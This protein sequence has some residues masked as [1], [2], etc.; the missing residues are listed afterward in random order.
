MFEQIGKS[1]LRSGI[2][3]SLLKRGFLVSQSDNWLF[4]FMSQIETFHHAM[5][6]DEL[7][8]TETALAKTRTAVTVVENGQIKYYYA[9]EFEQSLKDI[10]GSAIVVIPV[11]GMMLRKEN[12]YTR[13]GYAT[14]TEWLEK[15]TKI[16]KSN[17]NIKG[18][19]YKV[20]S[21]GGIGYGNQSLSRL[22]ATVEVPTVCFF[23]NCASAALESFKSCDYIIANE[24]DSKIGSY[25]SYI[26]YIFITK[27][28]LKEYGYDVVEV[29]APQS[30]HKNIESREAENGNEE[31]MKS[32]LQKSV[33]IMIEDMKEHRPQVTSDIWEDGRIFNAV[34]AQEINL[35][36]DIMS[37]DATIEFVQSLIPEPKQQ[38]GYRDGYRQLAE[39]INFN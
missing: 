30:T 11:N 35:V 1:I 2:S 22:I 39:N 25:G 34:E 5:E 7:A 24:S 36:D 21:G 27:D 28:G 12:Y 20:N 13:Y 38:N 9:S 15:V 10:E 4:S 17:S 16:C 14:S 33:A 19:I 18:I 23:D 3:Q 6:N 32:L 29:Y 8:K 26:K 31:P 37:L